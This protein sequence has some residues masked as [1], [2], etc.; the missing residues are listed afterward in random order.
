MGND[1]AHTAIARALTIAAS[2]ASAIITARTLGVEARGEYYFVLTAALLGAQIANL[3]LSSSNALLAARDAQ[4]VGKLLA[5]SFWVAFVLAPLAAVAVAFGTGAASQNPSR[6]SA[7]L[8]W[9]AAIAPGALFFTL[10]SNLLVGLREFRSYNGIT[11]GTAL[12]QISL[13]AAVALYRPSIAAFLAVSLACLLASSIAVVRKLRRSVSGIRPRGLDATVLRHSLG[14]AVRA[15]LILLFAYLLARMPVMV[16]GRL[17]DNAAVGIVSVVTQFLDVLIIL[18][19]SV[20][21]I[22]FPNLV[23]GKPSEGPKQA[24]RATAWVVTVMVAVCGALALIAEPLVV[25]LFGSDFAPSAA[26]LYWALPG[27][28][29]LS[30]VNVFGQ[31]MAASGFPVSTVIAWGSAAAIGYALAPAA[32]GP[33]APTQA[34]AALSAAYASLALLMG[35]IFVRSARRAKQ[36]QH[37]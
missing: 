15:F 5:N 10:S 20:A 23:A 3:G 14:F 29:L 30:A 17:G 25:L 32:S 2:V 16:F 19:A 8:W 26:A 37:A 4:L 35:L 36:A 27:L 31:Y 12:L 28:V 21:M 33:G 7:L 34:M 13:I 1:V 6:P 9:S 18:P 22:L 24:L 11:I